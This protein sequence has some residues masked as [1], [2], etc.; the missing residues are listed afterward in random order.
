MSGS[1]KAPQRLLPCLP[2]RA[3]GFW[4]LPGSS[5]SR[6][7][8]RRPAE[9]IEFGGP[10]LHADHDAKSVNYQPNHECGIPRRQIKN[11]VLKPLRSHRN[12][13]WLSIDEL[14]ITALACRGQSLR[15]ATA[16]VARTDRRADLRQERCQLPP[17]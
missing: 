12:D 13:G 3:A 15:P 1:V 5:L 16:N 8:F 17:R 10:G 14:F 9:P 2:I 6:V 11:D 4:R 7:L